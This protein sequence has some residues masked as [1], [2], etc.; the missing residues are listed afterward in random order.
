MTIG[1]AI[2]ETSCREN[3]LDQPLLSEGDCA[4]FDVLVEL[5]SEVFAKA[6]FFCETKT[7]RFKFINEGVD[8]VRLQGG[9]A[10]VIHVDDYQKIFLVQETR[11]VSGLSEAHVLEGGKEVLIPK[12][13]RNSEAILTFVELETGACR[14]CGAES[15]WQMDPDGFRKCGLNKG[16]GEITRTSGPV[17]NGGEDKEQ[18]N[19]GPRYNG[20]KGLEGIFLEITAAT[21]ASLVFLD[22]A[23]Q[24]LLDLEDPSAGDNLGL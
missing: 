18:T 12:S 9:N 1:I 4:L 20:S 23:I 24:G 3:L 8:H 7:A 16:I 13:W 14:T 5:D 15:S 22:F 6:S 2:S 19:G 10:Y 11:V 21:V 17:E